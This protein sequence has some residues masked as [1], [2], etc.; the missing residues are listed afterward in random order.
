MALNF[1]RFKFEAKVKSSI[2]LASDR[3]VGTEELDACVGR[4]RRL[5][6]DLR[7]VQSQLGCFV[8]HQRASFAAGRGLASSLKSFFRAAAIDSAAVLPP[9]GEGSAHHDAASG[10]AVRADRRRRA[11]G[12]FTGPDLG[13]MEELFGAG[14]SDPPITG[15]LGHVAEG[16]QVRSWRTRGAWEYCG[17]RELLGGGH[18]YVVL[19]T[20][21]AS[22]RAMRRTRHTSRG[23]GWGKRGATTTAGRNAIRSLLFLPVSLQVSVSAEIEKLL[24]QLVAAERKIVAVKKGDLRKNH[25]APERL[26]AHAWW[27]AL[28][29]AL[30]RP[31][32]CATMSSASSRPL[33]ASSRPWHV[34]L[35]WHMPGLNNETR[36]V[37]PAEAP[38]ARVAAHKDGELRGGGGGGP[39]GQGGRGEARRGGGGPGQLG[40]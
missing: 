13:P 11:S 31:L 39:R 14:A 33:H 35:L 27:R 16:I 6:S 4:V 24:N 25:G 36:R 12:A 10:E 37:L 21:A 5:I 8:H 18:T 26:R 29:H 30:G 2:G 34:R 9:R 22:A 3:V 7:V 20:R 38:G 17:A 23:G 32:A 1:Q 15:V 40:A 28:L 19:L